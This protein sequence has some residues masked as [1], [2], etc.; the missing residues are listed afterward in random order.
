M[1]RT[2]T[3]LKKALLT[4]YPKVFEALESSDTRSL[5]L[6]SNQVCHD[7][8][9]GVYA[10]DEAKYPAMPGGAE[11]DEEGLSLLEGFAGADDRAEFIRSRGQDGNAALVWL[12]YAALWQAGEVRKLRHVLAGV[13]DY[14]AG[15]EYREDGTVKAWYALGRHVA[16]GG[17]E[18]L[19]NKQV[20]RAHKVYRAGYSFSSDGL[21]SPLPEDHLRYY[22]WINER[23]LA[24]RD[25]HLAH[26]ALYTLGNATKTL[27]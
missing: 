7:G 14:V 9:L 11:I 8:D 2:K 25:L 15:A 12:L 26:K 10:Y 17:K 13:R 16:S 5:T 19:V 23:G 6:L 21:K 27:L 22:H 4:Y 1:K 24:P 18:P 20:T 3:R